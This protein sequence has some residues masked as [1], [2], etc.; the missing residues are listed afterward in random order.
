LDTTPGTAK[1]TCSGGNQLQTENW[2]RCENRSSTRRKSLH[3]NLRN[4]HPGNKNEAGMKQ[5]STKKNEKPWAANTE[6]LSNNTK[7]CAGHTP[8]AKKS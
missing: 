1:K 7:L 5:I 3:E 4:L 8:A 6:E 2:R